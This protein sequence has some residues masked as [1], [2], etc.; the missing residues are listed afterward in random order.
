MNLQWYPGHMTKAKRQMQED[1]KLIDLIIE[2]VDARVPMS[3]RN[4]D[5]DEMG[6]NKAR[7]ILLNKSDLADEKYNRKWAA[8]F[9][10]RGFQVAEVN[11]R[12]GAGLKSIQGAVQEACREKIERD[13]RRGIKNRPIRAMVVGIP[14]VG[15]STFINSYAG[16]A[17]AKTGNRPGVTRG[18][19]W[20]RLNRSLELLDTPGI[21]WPKFEDQQVGKNLAFIGS[22][23]DEILNLEELSLELLDMLRQ[24]YPGVLAA[25]YEISEEDTPLAMLETLARNR[26]CFGKGQEIDYARAAGILMEEF[27][28][29][30]LGRI[31]LEYPAKEQAAQK[32]EA[33]T[34]NEDS[35]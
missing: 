11:S 9:R 1:L 21:L 7:L 3:S 18:K 34:S 27:R 24:Y 13:R 14:N 33:E 19:Q 23:K 5:I 6:K 20:I 2:L 8:Y 35:Q 4:P 30:K 17:C 29:G 16:R 10:N 25:R 12:S 31:T 22:I 28:N 15:K 26:R 32:E